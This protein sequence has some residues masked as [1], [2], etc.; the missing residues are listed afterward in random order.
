MEL[1]KDPELTDHVKRFIH[2][3]WGSR[4]MHMFP[5]PHPVSLERRHFDIIQKGSYV[6]CEKTDGVRYLLVC[7]TFKERK[8]ALFV[9]RAFDLYSARLAIPRETILDGELV[10]TKFIIWDGMMVGGSSLMKLDL[11]SRLRASEP[12]T[13]GPPYGGIRIQMKKMWARS[14]LGELLR[15][16]FPYEIDGYV[17]TPVNEPVNI[18][19][20]ETMFKW[21][22]LSRITIDFLVQ[23][24][25]LYVWDR[26][27]GMVKVQQ[28][29][30]DQ[31]E[32][33]HI[34][35]CQ[36]TQQGWVYVKE[37][38]DKVHPNNRRTLLRTLIN[39][40][41]NIQIEELLPESKV[42]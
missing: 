11:I 17:F 3:V 18:E 15:T 38:T 16:Q 1:V 8:W 9:N 26:K 40:K 27:F 23:D 28:G 25:G 21:K 7:T 41:E 22:P 33:G 5:G 4:D 42:E 30:L 2:S 10:G 31:V 39:I 29:K 14:K 36:W 34:A 37:R 35:E 13:K 32:V 6:V 20:H 19:T 12:A 24:D